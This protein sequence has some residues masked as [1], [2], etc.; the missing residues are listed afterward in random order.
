MCSA[1]LLGAAADWSGG[2]SAAHSR[3]GL[4]LLCSVHAYELF[5]VGL[6]NGAL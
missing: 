1:R 6:F 3:H 5:E 4:Q 2:L